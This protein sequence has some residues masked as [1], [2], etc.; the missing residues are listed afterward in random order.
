MS[1]NT[2]LTIE[3]GSRF[4]ASGNPVESAY[5]DKKDN[6]AKISRTLWASFSEVIYSPS[7]AQE[8]QATESPVQNETKAEPISTPKASA[9]APVE[10]NLSPLELAYTKIDGAKTAKQLGFIFYNFVNVLDNEEDK[11]LA[12]QALNSRKKELEKKAA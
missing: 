6:K 7:S 9:S 12:Q 3:K 2:A 10:E 5:I 4:A 1:T 11:E 8:T